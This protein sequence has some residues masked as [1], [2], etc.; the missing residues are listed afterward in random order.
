MLEKG[1][2][3]QTHK[4]FG[5]KAV[6]VMNADWDKMTVDGVITSKKDFAAKA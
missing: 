6:K 5:K 2:L 1:Y 3:Y 4:F